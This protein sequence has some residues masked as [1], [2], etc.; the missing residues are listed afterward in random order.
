MHDCKRTI[1]IQTT[2]CARISICALVG[3]NGL[4]TSP[5]HAAL[6][7]YTAESAW[8]SAVPGPALVNFD[9]LANGTPVSNQY[10]GVSFAP[11]NSGTPLAAAESRP[12]SLF[13]VLSVDP[14]PNNAGVG[15]STGQTDILR[16]I[17]PDGASVTTLPVP[18]V[19]GLTGSIVADAVGTLCYGTT[20]GLTV[21]PAGGLPSILIPQ[22]AGIVLGANPQLLNVEALAI[23]GPRQ[24]VV[25]SGGQI[26]IVTLP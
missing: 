5:A 26:L 21:L 8:L 15:V 2:V 18:A 23:L 20:Q 4:A 1:E 6:T 9:K 3:L 24:L 25:L 16:R 17:A 14:L 11:F 7:V 10:A 13:N 12:L 22:G 19:S